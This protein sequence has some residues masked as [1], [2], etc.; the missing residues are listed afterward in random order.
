MKQSAIFGESTYKFS[1]QWKLTTGLRFF[2]FQV[3]NESDQCGVGTAT[4]SG[5]CTTGTASGSGSAVL[6]KVNLSYTPTPDLN[7]YGTIAKGS[8]PGGVNL[9]IPLSNTSYYFC[10]PGSGPVYLQ[11]Q[12]AYYQPDSIWSYEIGEKARFDD[13]RFSLNAD[14]FYVNWKNLQQV[15]ALSCGYPY[16]ANV[17]NAQ[18]Y[19][20]EVEFSALVTD[21]LTASLSGTYTE[22]KVTQAIPT[23]NGETGVTTGTPIL[24]VPKYTAMGAL[25]YSTEFGEHMTATFHIADSFVGPMTDIDY[26]QN[27]PIPSH[28][29][30]DGRAGISRDRWALYLT[31][32]NLTNKFAA[33]TTN[34]TTFAWQ[35]PSLARVSTNQ[36]R[37]IGLDFQY[38]F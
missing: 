35:Q 2:K 7:V 22:A 34:N 18:S 23:G 30:I 3:A 25:D 20:P 12:P 31:G 10:G 6:P 33:L 29:M 16:N 14:V 21:S 11:N 24:S 19:G 37:T 38:R 36:P 13:R 5:A 15:I 17:G 8:R 1:D 28:N 4:G 32:T 9:P 27:V 26:Y